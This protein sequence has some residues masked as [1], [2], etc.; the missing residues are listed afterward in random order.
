MVQVVGTFS[1]SLLTDVYKMDKATTTVYATIKP[2]QAVE[3]AK[4][5]VDMPAT[6][7]QGAPRNALVQR[8]GSR[9]AGA[10]G[11]VAA[12][13]FVHRFIVYDPSK[14]MTAKAALSHPF[15]A[16]LKQST[17]EVSRAGHTDTKR[18]VKRKRA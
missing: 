14:R 2:K 15:L 18:T 11:V 5:F 6:G 12:V 10:R 9:G 7:M 8:V 3:W 16:S 17:I 1:E 4:R 13:D